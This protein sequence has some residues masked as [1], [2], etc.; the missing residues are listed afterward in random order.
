M[1]T[2]EYYSAI[3]S[4]DVMIYTTMWIT[5]ENIMCEKAV[6]RNNTIYDPSSMKAQDRE[7]H[8]DRK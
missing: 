3:K 2:I 5:L 7:I 1:Y 6:K 8:R 4:N